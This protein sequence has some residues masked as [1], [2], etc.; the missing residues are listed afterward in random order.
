MP[1]PRR[2]HSCLRKTIFQFTPPFCWWQASDGTSTLLPGILKKPF[3]LFSIAKTQKKLSS[4][5]KRAGDHPRLRGE[6][7]QHELE[8]QLVEGSPPLAW[9]VLGCRKYCEY[10]RRITPACAGSTDPYIHH[11]QAFQDHPRLRGEYCLLNWCSRRFIG[12]PPL[13]RGVH[14]SSR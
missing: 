13:T 1:P 14:Y 6:Y 8:V 10:C 9:G 2:I 3:L 12:S 11:L 5:A 4:Y 7:V